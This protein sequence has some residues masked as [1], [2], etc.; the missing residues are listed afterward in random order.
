MDYRT[1]YVGNSPIVFQI[2][3]NYSVSSYTY[4]MIEKNLSTNEIL[5][6]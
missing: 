1:K 2:H 3:N 4:A 6:F 5:E